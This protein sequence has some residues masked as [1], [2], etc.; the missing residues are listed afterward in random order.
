MVVEVTAKIAPSMLSSDFA[1]LASEAERM[2]GCG[3]FGH[4]P[5][6]NPNNQVKRIDI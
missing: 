6:L 5:D 1:N 2:V 3:V 4:G